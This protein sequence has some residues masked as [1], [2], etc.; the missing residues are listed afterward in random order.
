M[1]RQ[2][3]QSMSLYPKLCR[4]QSLWHPI[5]EEIISAGERVP[6]RSNWAW[7]DASSTHRRGVEVLTIS[8]PLA[9]SFASIYVISPQFCVLVI[10]ISLRSRGSSCFGSVPFLS[11][12]RFRSGDPYSLVIIVMNA[13][14]GFIV[15]RLALDGEILALIKCEQKSPG[16]YSTFHEQMNFYQFISQ[17]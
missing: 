10:R 7:T 6:V 2:P 3:L 14:I 5:R 9:W 16:G 11:H 1:E 8:L 12:Q 4:D 13:F 17:P 15:Y